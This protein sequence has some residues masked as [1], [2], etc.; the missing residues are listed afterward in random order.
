[1]KLSL[2]IPLGLLGLSHALKLI[3][4]PTPVIPNQR[5]DI[6]PYQAEKTTKD[7]PRVGKSEKNLSE[8]DHPPEFFDRPCVPRDKSHSWGP[9]YVNGVT[10]ELLF[11]YTL[12]EFVLVRRKMPDKANGWCGFLDFSS[13]GCTKSIDNPFNFPFI[14]ACF[15]HDFGYQ[16]YRRQFRF[17]VDNK[18]R[19]D[20]NF[21]KDLVFR[22][23]TV[24]A[25]HA[26]IRLAELYH[27]GVQV[28][29]GR[30]ATVKKKPK[31]RL[32]PIEDH[33]PPLENRKNLVIRMQSAQLLFEQ[34]VRQAQS[35]QLLPRIKPYLLKIRFNATEL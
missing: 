35:K 28:Y 12:N 22:C 31:G 10:D 17:T 5:R 8:V 2:I 23:Q 13:D 3:P 14:D 33:T 4:C 34:A 21:L 7:E 15:R 11:R 16:N 9:A 27:L 25:K 1:M 24:K 20:D 30:D 6:P 26:C 32:F 18:K 29:G 19:I